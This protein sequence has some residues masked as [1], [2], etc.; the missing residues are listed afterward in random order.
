MVLLAACTGGGGASPDAGPTT[1]EAPDA[2]CEAAV[3]SIVSAT[4]RYV[5]GYESGREASATPPVD[6]DTPEVTTTTRDAGSDAITE[7]DFQAALTEAQAAIRQRECDPVQARA[8]LAAGLADVDA[9]GP[10]A[11]A[12]L[13]QLTASVTGR[14][15]QQPEV[16]SVSV[17]D[18]LR[19]ALAASPD[20]S[21]LELGPGEYRIDEPLVVLAGVE[22]RG[23]GRDET[24]IVSTAPEASVLVVTDR[25]VELTDL[26]LRREGDAPGSAIL[27]GPAASI[28]V[29][30]ARLSGA[31]NGPDGQ[32]GAGILMFA[33]EAE[34]AGRGTTLEVTNTELRDNDAAGILL[35]GGHRSSI[36]DAVFTS[37]GQCGICFIGAA[38]GSVEDS[39]FDDN[40][41]GI[42]ATG[43]AQP[44]LLRIVVN[45][46]EVGVQAADT[47]APTIVDVT[48][49]GA[50]RAAVIY[51]GSASGSLDRVTCR[52]VPFG[53]VVSP[54]A[55][56]QL[57]ETNCDLARSD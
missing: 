34:A 50:T 38:D 28:V 7:D 20:G 5:R 44:T 15:A 51:A 30:G 43:A 3:E 18:D 53:I 26:T 10:V 29:S 42:A 2:E 41:A 1:T 52:D 25:R 19:D 13:R 31:R 37:N 11:D 12:V 24:A 35:T 23:A 17:G 45:G 4:Q 54:Q 47:A 22:I 21:T 14:L 55:R 40:G 6:T 57:G 56:P 32:G 46:G 9:S 33:L 49:S 8:D 39:S 16:T 36:V 48:V 27:G